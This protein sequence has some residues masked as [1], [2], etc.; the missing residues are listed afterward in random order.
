[1]HV[2]GILITNNKSYKIRYNLAGFGY[3]FINDKH[4]IEY[5]DMSKIIPDH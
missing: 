2:S 3:V 5:G 4:F 1:V